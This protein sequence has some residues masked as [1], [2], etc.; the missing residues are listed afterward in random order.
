MNA[1]FLSP[2]Q[3]VQAVSRVRVNRQGLKDTTWKWYQVREA[4]LDLKVIL[5]GLICCSL[6]I[7][8]GAL[9]AVSFGGFTCLPIF[10]DTQ[11]IVCTDHIS[12]IWLQ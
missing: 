8:T 3:R 5:P 9:N 1:R 2:E 7:T 6:S 11:I 12:R 4:L 10:A